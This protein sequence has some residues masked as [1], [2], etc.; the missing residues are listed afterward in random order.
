MQP[1][2]L[3]WKVGPQSREEEDRAFGR[4][5]PADEQED[6]PFSLLDHCEAGQFWRVTF[7]RS[8]TLGPLRSVT[9]AG[10]EAR[11]MWRHFQALYP[12]K[13]Y[14]VFRVE[15]LPITPT[16]VGG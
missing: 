3:N 4:E 9:V 7:R 14:T 1:L 13:R 8:L 2:S 16:P 6:P 12:F 11:D 5:W 10:W 15:Q